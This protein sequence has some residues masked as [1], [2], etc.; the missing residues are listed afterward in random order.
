MWIGA[1]KQSNVYVAVPKGNAIC[2]HTH[3]QSKGDKDIN[4]CTVAI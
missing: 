3:H 4:P 2:A 1:I